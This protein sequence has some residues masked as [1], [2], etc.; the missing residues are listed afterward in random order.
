MT[1]AR[2][3]LPGF[4]GTTLPAW[5]EARLRGGLGGVCLF[6][7]N[8]ESRE[9]LLALTAAITAANPDALIA[10]D[11]EGGDVSR[12]YQSTGAPFPGNALLGRIDD[13]DY[14]ARVAT[15]V[16][17][18]WAPWGSTSTS[19]PTSTSTRTPTTR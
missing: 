11:E 18:S 13:L 15:A 16:V 19:R 17:S 5:L 14:T 7:E 12:L 10:I 8:V 3:L 2:V 6:G 9:Q 1:A 4:V